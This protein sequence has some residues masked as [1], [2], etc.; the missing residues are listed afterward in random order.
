[1]GGQENSMTPLTV[2]PA[3]ESATSAHLCSAPTGARRPRLSAESPRPHTGD[4]VSSGVKEGKKVYALSKVTQSA[5]LIK[6]LALETQLAGG[7]GRVCPRPSPDHG[8]TCRRLLPQVTGRGPSLH[9]PKE[10]ASAR[11]FTD[12]PR[13]V[14]DCESQRKRRKSQRDRRDEAEPYPLN[15]RSRSPP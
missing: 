15:P 11:L 10:E 13:T 12:F 8:C 5:H 1:M 9:P 14:P 7:D 6:V 4:R 2:H 3:E